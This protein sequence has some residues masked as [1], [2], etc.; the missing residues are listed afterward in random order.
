MSLSD[1]LIK[2]RRLSGDVVAHA[3]TTAGI[4]DVTLVEALIETG[5]ISE[6]D[7][8]SWMHSQLGFPMVDDAYFA[9]IE[10]ATLALIPTTQAIQLR[11]LPL[12]RAGGK[13][14]VASLD[15]LNEALPALAQST[16]H[17]IIVCVARPSAVIGALNQRYGARLVIPIVRSR[18]A[19]TVVPP[20]VAPV[21]NTGLDGWMR[22]LAPAVAP[23][24]L[25]SLPVTPQPIPLSSTT[26]SAPPLAAPPLAAP[27]LVAP[28]LAAPR[29][30]AATAP[31]V[32]QAPAPAA[33]PRAP[34]IFDVPAPAP[35]A[36][37]S[38][39][40]F[41]ASPS[42]PVD[43][44]PADVKPAA[45]PTFS[46]TLTAK[47]QP[48]TQNIPAAEAPLELTRAREFFSSGSPEYNESH[49]GGLPEAFAFSKTRQEL[50]NVDSA[51]GVSALLCDFASRYFARIVV[52][53]HRQ[54]MLLGVRS[55]G[56][57][58]S[59]TRLRGLIVPLHATSVF[60]QV[61]E[62]QAYFLGRLKRTMINSAFLSA[63]GDKQH[64]SALVVPVVVDK[65][66]A[67]V[68]YAD[69]GG[70]ELGQ[71]DLSELYKMCEATGERLLDLIRQK[72]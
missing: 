58:L 11:V 59:S 33:K 6:A 22:D 25:A 35:V 21:A 13:L 56:T 4:S 9:K 2:R 71:P 50:A 18:P 53:A 64:G 30:P 27:P 63:L 1:E 19:P 42:Q 17:Q 28:P 34:S 24:T 16:G 57:D 12:Y 49:S 69:T 62:S 68:L 39:S 37:S 65:R 5:A 36:P 40:L 3:Q 67:L 54:D 23:T 60:K 15:P 41:D 8:V 20:V 45:A 44:R 43:L 7:F 70:A 29:A 31:P 48:A 46:P 55:H 61:V 38:R 51:E 26:L 47:A 52:L 72:P 66:V 32:A 14:F 10:T